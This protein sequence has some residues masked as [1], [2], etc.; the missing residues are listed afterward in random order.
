MNIFTFE[1]LTI[2]YICTFLRYLFERKCEITV[3]F[4]FYFRWWPHNSCL[5]DSNT[6]SIEPHQMSGLFLI[7]AC[8]L[9]IALSFSVVE[10]FYKSS[11]KR[12]YK[13]RVCIHTFDETMKLGI[14]TFIRRDKRLHLIRY[15]S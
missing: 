10:Y 6:S 12:A 4:P 1:V 14:K 15:D 13:T 5:H 3:L 2:S 7:L 9:L 11:K 8:G